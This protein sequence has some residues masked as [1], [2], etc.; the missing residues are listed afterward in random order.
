MRLKA[1]QTSQELFSTILNRAPRPRLTGR[2]GCVAS[3]PGRQTTFLP[4]R[5]A[6]AGLRRTFPVQEPT[7]PAQG[8]LFPAQATTSPPQE[9]AFPAW[10]TTFPG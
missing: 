9:T 10:E 4:L 6:H 5:T 3:F 7:S 8:A 1:G 2:A